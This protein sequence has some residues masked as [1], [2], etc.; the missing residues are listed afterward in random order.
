MFKSP[1][2]PQKSFSSPLRFA[3][4]TGFSAH[5]INRLERADFSRDSRLLAASIAGVILGINP[6]DEEMRRKAELAWETVRI[7]LADHLFGDENTSLPWSGDASVGSA[8]SNEIL[9]KRYSEIRSLARTVASVSFETGADADIAGAGK[10]L[11]RLAV[12]LD[13][14]ME[15]TERRLV[16]KLRQYVFSSGEETR[17]SA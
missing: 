9:K 6:R 13:D 15:D 1:S 5:Q 17:L 3:P 4:R 14:L 10:A 11:C 8:T 16:N 12:K 7:L 2:S